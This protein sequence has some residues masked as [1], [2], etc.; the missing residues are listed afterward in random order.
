VSLN[1][2]RELALVTEALC[3]IF[4]STGR[5]MWSHHVQIAWFLSR[6]MERSRDIRRELV[7]WMT[8]GGSA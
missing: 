1:R 6:R 2:A 7:G 4:R 3:T 8:L 5:E